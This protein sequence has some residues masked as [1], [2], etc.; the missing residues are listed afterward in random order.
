MTICD[1]RKRQVDSGAQ[2]IQV[3][4][5][6]AG[7]L[8]PKDYD[9][10]AAPYQVRTVVGF[11]GDV[12][13]YAAAKTWCKEQRGRTEVGYSSVA[14]RQR[15]VVGLGS[16]ACHMGSC[17]MFLDGRRNEKE[18]RAARR[19]DASYFVHGKTYMAASLDMA[20][21]LR[22]SNSR[23]TRSRRKYSLSRSWMVVV[24]LLS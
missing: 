6:W 12:F 16:V 8:S 9:V 7:H 24:G 4:D 15:I 3:F 22:Q 11:L 10:F 18:T 13:A 23:K 21:L 5:S 14:C 17:V 2:V 1:G 19:G 20:A